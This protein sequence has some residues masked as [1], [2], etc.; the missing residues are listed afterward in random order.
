MNEF[1]GSRVESKRNGEGSSIIE[2]MN[3]IDYNSIKFEYG[4]LVE[5]AHRWNLSKHSHNLIEM[6][7]LIDAKAYINMSD[8]TLYPTWC[9]MVVYPPHHIHQEYIDMN[10]AQK[11]MYIQ[12]DVKSSLELT[13]PFKVKDTDGK[14]Y[15]LLNE[16]IELSHK[17]GVHREN[18]LIITYI[19]AILINMKL[20]LMELEENKD[21]VTQAINYIGYSYAEEI[22]VDKLAKNFYVSPSYISRLFHKRLGVSP[23]NYVAYVRIEAAKKLLCFSREQ[24][25]EIAVMIGIE[26]PKYFSRLFKKTTHYTPSEFRKKFG[27]N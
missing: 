1:R 27:N 23:M 15:W 7:Y 16:I 9:D 22:T 13:E 18:E 24:V 19:K 12:F 14:L 20:Y 11:C 2:F 4:E 3:H 5:E 21:I 26:D 10:Y 25:N 8:K 6:I 17:E